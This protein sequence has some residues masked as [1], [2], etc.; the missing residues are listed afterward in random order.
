M[1]DAYFSISIH[2]EC[3]KYLC[4]FWR[5]QLYNFNVL[6]FGIASAPR[7]FTNVL[8]PVYALFRR[9][10]IRCCYHI[11][12]S[13]IMNQ[14]FEKCTTETSFVAS[15]ID[16]LGFT[17]NM[18]KSVFQPTQRNVFFGLVIDTIEFKVFLTEEKIVKILSLCSSILKERKVTI[19][20]L[21]WTGCSMLSMQYYL[22]L[23]I[24]E[25]WKEIK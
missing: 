18:K 14:D 22:D 15:E 8:K 11:D 6:P 4:F 19:R 25:I 23:C 17:V 16:K 10:D 2:P 21:N 7:V 5:D 9:N 24:T 20:F 1:K 13:L 12:D 3:Q